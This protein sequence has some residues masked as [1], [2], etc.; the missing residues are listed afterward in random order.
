MYLEIKKQVEL[1]PKKIRMEIEFED[2]LSYIV[3]RDVEGRTS[4]QGIIQTTS[5]MCYEAMSLAG[6]HILKDQYKEINQET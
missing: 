1:K 3:Y 5:E 2:G 4:I 6:E